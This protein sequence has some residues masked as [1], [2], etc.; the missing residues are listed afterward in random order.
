MVKRLVLAFVLC[1]PAAAAAQSETFVVRLGTDVIAQETFTRNASRLEGE[2]SGGAFP[3][4]MNYLLELTAGKPTTM[5]LD[6]TPNGSDTATVRVTMQF[7]GDSVF[8]QQTRAGVPQPEQRLATQAGAMPFINLSF[9]LSELVMAGVKRA[10]GDSLTAPLF[11][12]GNGAT[13]SARVK[14]IAADSALMTLGGVE[15]RMHLD[16]RGRILHATVPSQNVTIERVA[17]TL[18]R[19][20]HEAPDYSAPAGAAYSAENV[21]IKTPAGHTL[22]G[23]LT[24]PKSRTGRVPAVIT[25]TGSGPQDRDEALTG[26]RGY[27]PFRQIAESLAAR[28]VAV[29]R[30]DDRGYGGSTGVHG[31][32]TSLDF[33]QD[34]RAALTWLRARPEIDAARVFLLGHSEGGLI[35]PLVAAED[36]TLAG[37]V[38][39]AGPAYVG[40]RILEYQTRHG[41]DLQAGKTPAE[42]DS[43]F[44]VT[45]QSLDSAMTQQPWLGFFATHDPL[46]VVRRVRVP[47]LI[48]HGATDRQ[49]TADQ[50]EILARELRSSGNTDVALH[51]LPE[52][53]HLFLKDPLGHA[54]GYSALPSRTVVPELLQ[55]VADWIAK[56][57]K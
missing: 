2:L 37:I 39:L 29:L 3:Q 28:G 18:S 25:I 57:S 34:A 19:A 44:R 54:Q 10:V 52:V 45:M 20:A 38:V 21:S 1:I 53:N 16:A 17:G 5:R 42:R 13:M 47:V 8:V 55:M 50:A 40:R 30:Y 35:A 14:W 4:R 32:A 6:V 24:L 27:R 41:L 36:T 15:L 26:M 56:H 33:A 49:V 31:V 12:V 22:A 46:P 48:I 11:V 23:T 43:L 9:A 7:A 51:V